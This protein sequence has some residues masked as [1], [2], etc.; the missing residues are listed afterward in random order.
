MAEVDDDDPEELA[1]M[2]LHVLS[3]S[4]CIEIRCEAY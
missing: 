1:K 3:P 4:P 2:F